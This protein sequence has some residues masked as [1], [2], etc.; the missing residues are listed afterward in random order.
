ISP[1]ATR[2]RSVLEA[3]LSEADVPVLIGTLGKAV[4]TSGA[5]VAGPAVL[6]DYLVQKARTYIYT[7][8]MPPALAKATCASIDLIE[9]DDAR[10]SHL[11]ALIARFRAG[12]QELGYQLMPS[13]T[14]IQPI[15]VRSEERRVG[16]ECRSRWAASLAE[17]DV[18]V[19]LRS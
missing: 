15:M 2:L 3:G 17:R 7:T 19:S 10:R 16:K 13:Y 12:A 5:F 8:A 18:R 11:R 14:P 4:G 6:M 9:R 1:Y